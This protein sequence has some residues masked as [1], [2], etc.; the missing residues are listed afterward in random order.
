MPFMQRRLFDQSTSVKIS[1]DK[2][3]ELVRL[4]SAIDWDRLISLAMDIRSR[5]FDQMD[6]NLSKI[7]SIFEKSLQL[8]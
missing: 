3:H 4:E 1:V 5:P 8:Q 7:V 6:K 2:S